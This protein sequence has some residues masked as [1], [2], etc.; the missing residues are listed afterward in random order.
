MRPYHCYSHVI[1]AAIYAVGK[2]DLWCCLS[3]FGIQ[4][5]TI[6]IQALGGWW[7]ECCNCQS[8]L[9]WWSLVDLSRLSIN[10]Q[11]HFFATW[12]YASAAYA[13][14]QCL[15]VHLSATFMN[16]VKT[17]KYYLPNLFTVRYPHH[18]SFSTPNVTAIFR[19]GP[20]LTGV[21]N[22]GGAGR[23]HNSEPIS[24]LITCCQCYYRLGVINTVLPDRGKLWH[25]LLVVS[26]SVC[27]WQEMMTKC[28]WQEVL[29][30]YQK[31]QNSI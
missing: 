19:R 11:L 1:H 2:W 28:L 20:P 18:S 14:M 6:R 23:N 10:D 30:L 9:H 31:Q 8:T 26:G 12:C 16:S 17:N 5:G 13:T 24:G 29:T 22:V 27:W 15:C 25:L 21:L 4:R 7:R 3:K